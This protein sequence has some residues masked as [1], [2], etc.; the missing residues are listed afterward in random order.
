MPD[1]VAPSRAPSE[2]RD[3]DLIELFLC[4]R[5]LGAVELED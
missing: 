3:G 1:S 2:R 5:L 4:A